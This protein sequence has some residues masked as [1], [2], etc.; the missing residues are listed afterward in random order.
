MFTLEGTLNSIWDFFARLLVTF[1]HSFFRTRLFLNNLINN[2]DAYI[3]AKTYLFISVFTN[4]FI[5]RAFQSSGDNFLGFLDV[6]Y[7][8]NAFSEVKHF[9]VIDIIV[10]S[11]PYAVISY[12]LIT[13]M[14]KCLRVD[15]Y[16]KNIFT[17]N[18]LYLF[19]SAHLL[20]CL[21]LLSFII[22]EA[23][24]DKAF[25][26]K[27]AMDQGVIIL[28]YLI[29]G[30]II[31]VLPIVSV[32]K[33]MPYLAGGT[34]IKFLALQLLALGSIVSTLYP[35]YWGNEM[36]EWVNGKVKRSTPVKIYNS[37]MRADEVIIDY[38]RNNDSSAT[39][40]CSFIIENKSKKTCYLLSDDSLT[41][42]FKNSESVFLDND[43]KAINSHNLVQLIKSGDF[44]AVYFDKHLDKAS[45]V[46][47]DSLFQKQSDS[48]PAN[49]YFN[50]EVIDP[51]IIHGMFG[52]YSE[53]V[54]GVFDNFKTVSFRSK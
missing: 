19:A 45:R 2:P 43:R 14:V 52:E 10:A 41:V 39:I 53:E 34:R 28:T 29:I 54:D 50:L 49:I 23:L 36:T 46:F 40:A 31:L 9:T 33:R 21:V 20:F 27:G 15:R 26:G 48:I 25:N 51:T 35:F 44:L 30:L 4:Y 16:W 5:Y 22:T 17:A 47:I 13:L 38:H 12:F 24:V 1:Y 3:S 11:A 32:L 18:T 42:A 8:Q 6:E 7:Y 37:R